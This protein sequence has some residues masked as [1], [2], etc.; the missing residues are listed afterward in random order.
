[1]DKKSS[2]TVLI[3]YLSL[4]ERRVDRNKHPTYSINHF[5]NETDNRSAE[6]VKVDLSDWSVSVISEHWLESY[7]KSEFLDFCLYREKVSGELMLAC[8]LSSRDKNRGCLVIS[9]N[10]SRLDDLCL[11]YTFTAEDVELIRSISAGPVKET[12]DDYLIIGTRKN[13]N[14]Y[15]LSQDGLCELIDSARYGAQTTN[16]REA[17]AA[18]LNKNGRAFVIA[19][20]S[21]SDDPSMKWRSTPGNIISFMFDNGAWQQHVIDSFEGITHS[22]M[23]YIGS[24]DVAQTSSF[25]LYSAS[26]GIY[27]YSKSKIIVP[28]NLYCYTLIN[29]QWYR[30]KIDTFEEAIKARAIA[31]GDVLGIKTNQIIVGTRNPSANGSTYLFLY[32]KLYDDQWTRLV[33]DRS[34][35]MGFHCVEIVESDYGKYII[36]SDDQRGQIKKY[37]FNGDKFLSDTIIDMPNSIFVTKI[38]GI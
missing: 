24:S 5:N 38:L 10:V 3:S 9:G 14:L 12:D 20:I 28:S 36:A 19:T 34:C 2:N 35:E 17:L 15:V 4:F 31:V 7:R 6:L 23:L 27:D 21:R 1:M 32:Y 30:N 26:V 13:G 11:H 37:W 33:I 22:R 8:A 18:V 25:Q 16:I 29:N